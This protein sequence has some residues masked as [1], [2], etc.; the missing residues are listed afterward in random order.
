KKAENQQHY[1]IT[2]FKISYLENAKI[3]NRMCR[4][5]FAH[6]KRNEA[7][8]GDDRAPHNHLRTEP[9]ELLSFVQHDLQAR[10]PNAEQPE[11]EVIDVRRGRTFQIRRILEKCATQHGG[12]NTDGQINIEDLAPGVIVG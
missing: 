12:E 5:Q 6:E 10:E 7:V 2:Y 3:D 1:N 4:D 9:I 11:A 8:G